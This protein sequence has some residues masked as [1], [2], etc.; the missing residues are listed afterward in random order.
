MRQRWSNLLFLHWPVDPLLIRSRL[1]EGLEPDLFDG[2]AWLGV[3]PFAMERVHPVGLPPL[4]WVSWFLELN[5]RTYVHD[6]SGRSGVWFFS[7]DCNQPVAVEA[8]RRFFHLPYHHARMRA[9]LRDG[10]IVYSCRRRASPHESRFRYRP[11]HGGAPAREHSLEWFLVERYLLFTTDR[12]GRIRSGRV[13]HEP[14]RLAE[15]KC[16]EWSSTPVD[17]DG[18]GRLGGPPVSMLAAEPVDVRIYPLH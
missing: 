16:R 4:P 10:E 7:L 1:P 2:Q 9:G 14:Y 17:D 18:L 12:A 13:H 5:V 11:A 3:V 6:H 8:A 15:A